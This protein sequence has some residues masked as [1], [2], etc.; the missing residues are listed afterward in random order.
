MPVPARSGTLPIKEAQWALTTLREKLIK[1]GALIMRHSRHVVFQRAEVAVP[2][3]LYAATM[4]QIDHLRGLPVAADWPNRTMER[5][6]PRGA[7]C[8]DD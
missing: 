5:A 8:A 3:A 6:E 7:I 4:G 2:R 1:I